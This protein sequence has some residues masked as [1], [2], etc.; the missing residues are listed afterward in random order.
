M[1]ELITNRL[2]DSVWTIVAVI[3]E[4]D[5]TARVLRYDRENVLGYELEK[6]CR[7]GFFK[8]KECEDRIVDSLFISKDVYGDEV[9]DK[10][11]VVNPKNIF[12][13]K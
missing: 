12:S 10:Y 3:D 13:Y 9:L 11:E 7:H 5:K 2:I 6:E 1:V 4:V 8:E